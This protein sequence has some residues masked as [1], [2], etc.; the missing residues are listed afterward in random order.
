MAQWGGTCLLVEL[1]VLWAMEAGGSVEIWHQVLHYPALSLSS[2]WV[3]VPAST[4]TS[5]S[6]SLPLPGAQDLPWGWWKPP[7]GTDRVER[8]YL[9]EPT[10]EGGPV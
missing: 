7:E 3:P 1:G 8:W 4:L 5:S 9:E 10:I 2:Q 6:I